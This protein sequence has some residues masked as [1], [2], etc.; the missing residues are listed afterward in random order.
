[1]PCYPFLGSEGI[2]YRLKESNAK[3]SIVCKEKEKEVS[4][5]LVPHLIYSEKLL[6]L[7]E[8]TESGTGQLAR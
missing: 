7:I 8:N 6:G 5:C 2:Q 1:M 3:V 4:A